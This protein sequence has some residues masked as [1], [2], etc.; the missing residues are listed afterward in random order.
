[1]PSPTTVVYGGYDPSRNAG[2]ARRVRRRGDRRRRLDVRGA[3]PPTGR[4]TQ[5]RSSRRTARSLPRCTTRHCTAARVDTS[6]PGR[7][8]SKARSPG[9]VLEVRIESIAIDLPYACN[10]FG[11]RGG[12]LPEDFPGESRFARDPARPHAH[13]GA[14]L[15]FARNRDSAAS[16]LREH[17]RRAAARSRD[18]STARRPARTRGISTTRRSSPARSSTS[19]CT[20][21]ARYSRSATATRGRATARWTSPRSRRRCAAGSS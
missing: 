16:V 18:A 15:R 11:P 3:A 2:A 12:F 13:G 17:R 6:S 9:D 4:S 1:M 19:R 14:L 5:A 8:T 21:A 7:S 10:A 20:R